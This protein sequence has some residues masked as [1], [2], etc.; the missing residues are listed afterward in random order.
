MLWKLIQP[1]V[2][3]VPAPSG[4]CLRWTGSK[5]VLTWVVVWE[6]RAACCA[7]RAKNPGGFYPQCI[8]VPHINVWYSFI[9]AFDIFTQPQIVIMVIMVIILKLP[10]LV[11][12]SNYGDKIPDKSNWRC[13]GFFWL[14]VWEHSP[15]WRGRLGF[16]EC[17]ASGCT[18]SASRER[19]MLTLRWLYPLPPFYIV[20]GSSP[21]SHL[22]WAF[23]LS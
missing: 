3:E 1:I 2:F 19:R 21:W 22:K 7:S 18:M 5:L 14:V 10:V 16:P 17:E 20:Q 8:S 15:S 23:S 11:V 12:F 4:L 6:M 9:W 13:Q